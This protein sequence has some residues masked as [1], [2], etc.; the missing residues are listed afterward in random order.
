M[1]CIFCTYYILKCGLKQQ[2]KQS[3]IFFLL[4]I[5]LVYFILTTSS[6][7][8]LPM[9]GAKLFKFTPI[10]FFVLSRQTK[11]ANRFWLLFKWIIQKKYQIKYTSISMQRDIKIPYAAHTLLS[12][13]EQSTQ[14]VQHPHIQWTCSYL[15]TAYAYIHEQT[16]MSNKLKVW[17][18][19]KLPKWDFTHHFSGSPAINALLAEQ[20]V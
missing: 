12:V 3:T 16:C 11:S 10:S 15:G 20:S 7:L 13:C 4:I 5:T 9:F 2:N 8:E 17:Q 14:I 18:W 19:I 6:W 1:K